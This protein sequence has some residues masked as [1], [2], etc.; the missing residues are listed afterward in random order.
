MHSPVM[1]F[2]AGQF[3]CWPGCLQ[4]GFVNDR[5]SAHGGQQRSSMQVHRVC[6]PFWSRNLGFQ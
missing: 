6:C 1:C 4:C 3:L 5:E 2:E